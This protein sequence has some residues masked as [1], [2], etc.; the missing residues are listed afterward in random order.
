MGERGVRNWACR[1]DGV[2]LLEV[3]AEGGSKGGVLDVEGLCRGTG[4]RA[5]G[6]EEVGGDGVSISKYVFLA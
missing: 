6:T 4:N 2:F 1:V 3:K 5:G